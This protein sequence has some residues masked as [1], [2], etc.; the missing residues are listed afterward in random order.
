MKVCSLCSGSKGNCT[1]IDVDGIKILIDAGMSYKYIVTSLNQIG[2]EITDIKY[3]FITHCHSD[4]VSSLKQILK[5]SGAKFCTTRLLLRS[6]NQAL[7]CE[8]VV[9][10]DEI[11]VGDN[12][13]VKALNSSHD[14]LDAKNYVIESGN[15]KVSIIT[16]TGYVKQKHFNDYYNSDII[17]MESNHDIEILNASSYPIYLK[18]RIYGDN[19]HLS[20]NQAGFYLTKLI[21]PRTGL[22]LLIHLSE[23]NN[24]PSLAL[25][26]VQGILDDYGI[27][28]SNIQI[29]EQR[30][31]SEVYNID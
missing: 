2:V 18:K 28:F 3:V 20:N 23:E 29:A 17:L 27:N 13:K 6:L 15:K 31:V 4:H 7:I 5:S 30:V 22:V 10:F 12:F 19:G 11:Y 21:G 25:D 9:F 26:T 1:F 14:A 8:N 16:D 24:D